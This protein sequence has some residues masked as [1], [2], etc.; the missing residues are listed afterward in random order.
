MG[1]SSLGRQET[2]LGRGNTCPCKTAATRHTYTGS[3]W[4]RM[5]A[6]HLHFITYLSSPPIC[7]YAAD[8]CNSVKAIYPDAGVAAM[9]TH[10]WTDRKFSVDSLNARRPVAASDDLIV[11]CCPDPFGAEECQRAVR[12]ASEQDEK[13]GALERPLVMFNQRLSR[14]VLCVSSACV[15]QLTSYAGG[16]GSDMMQ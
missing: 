13:A 15:H 3:T 11:I 8:G 2:C 10:E 5:A 16:C 7:C 14:C 6:P 12:Q 1:K 9:L 4:L